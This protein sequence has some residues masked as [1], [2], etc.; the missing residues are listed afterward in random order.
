MINIEALTGYLIEDI[1][2]DN[3]K[4]LSD[5]DKVD[6]NMIDLLWQITISNK[7]PQSWRAAWT[8]FHLVHKSRKELMRPYLTQILELIPNFKH[9]GQKRE[10]LKVIL[11]FDVEE[12]DMGIALEVAYELL[13]NPKEALAVRV[14]AMQLIFNISEVEQDLKYELKATLLHLMPNTSPGFKGR[15][16]RLLDKMKGV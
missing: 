1:S 5:S 9:N 7:H 12:I 11:L 8:I 3:I 15:S 16:K 14:H 4:Q 6:Q 10:L 2:T 13:N